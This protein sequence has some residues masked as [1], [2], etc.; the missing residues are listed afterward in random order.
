MSCFA[1]T[2]VMRSGIVDPSGWQ[3]SVVPS[4]C[5]QDGS[6][7]GWLRWW[8]PLVEPDA[9][10]LWQFPDGD[11]PFARAVRPHLDSARAWADVAHQQHNG[12]V[13]ARMPRADDVVIQELVGERE[14]ELGRAPDRLPMAHRES[15]PLATSGIWWIDG[16]A[17]AVDE[18]TRNEPILY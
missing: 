4:A 14:T 9:G 16:H 2:C 7:Y 1:S 8:I 18:T 5:H 12:S 11:D 17:I 3:G 10:P 15:L 6:D 13:I